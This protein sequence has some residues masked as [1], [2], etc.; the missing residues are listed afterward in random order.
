MR[1]P[2]AERLA[3]ILV[4]Y[5]TKVKEGEIVA[6]DGDSAAEPLLL[7]VYEEVL[8]AGGNPIMNVALGGQSAS[9]YKHSSDA[10][11]DWVSPVAELLLENADVRIA[12][13][14]STNTRELSAIP[15]ERQTR[16]QAAMGPL[17]SRAMER[18]VSSAGSTPCSRPMPMPP[19]QR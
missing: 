18:S 5:S 12:I 4:G 1:D 2:R 19:R 15:P 6:I 16:R 13:G 9:Y 17:L 7:A 14:A 10:Q 11:L 8:K 3:K